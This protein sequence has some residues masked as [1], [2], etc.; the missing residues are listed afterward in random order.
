MKDWYV[1]QADGNHIG[2][3]STD[4]LARGIIAGKVPRDAHLGARGD[5][6]WYPLLSIPEI[7]QTIASLQGQNV[8]PRPMSSVPPTAPPGKDAPTLRDLAQDLSPPAP[9]PGMTAPF[10][11]PAP[12]A[13]QAAPALAPPAPAVAEPA[14]EK[15]EEKKSPPLPP[16]TKYIPIAIF[17]ACAL[18]ALIEVGVSLAISPSA[19]PA[20]SA[21]GA[22]SAANK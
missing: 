14:A 17:G 20:S 12:Y 3:V 13:Q 4:L 9:A 15:K 6:Q 11:P 18:I 16:A 7:Q 19:P 22:S 1:Y 8:G 5:T 2:P 10:A 21:G